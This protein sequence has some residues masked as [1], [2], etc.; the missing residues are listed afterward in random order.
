MHIKLLAGTATIAAS[1]LT[2]P[3]PAFAAIDLVY[4]G[5]YPALDQACNDQLNPN[6]N[7]DF[8]TYAIVSGAPSVSSSTV[9]TGPTVYVGIGPSSTTLTYRDA[10]VNGKSVNIHAYGDR[11]V[12][13]AGGAAGTTP[14][15]T[16]VVT[17]I[18]A[19]CHVHKPTNG[20]SPSDTLHNDF[21]APPGLQ[22]LTASSTSTDYITGTRSSSLQGPWID[23]NASSYGGEFV[24]C[25][26]PS[27][28]TVKGVP[29][30]WKGQNGYTNQLGR[31]CSTT[32]HDQLGTSVS[33]SLPPLP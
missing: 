12:T 11:V 29:G 1:L 14:T 13:Y 17:T 2:V 23:L 18:N 28:T 5:A 8:T 9:D 26:S 32:W 19:G 25:I 21:I 31:V 27:S 3:T 24:I 15:L 30:V 20:N 33:V 10:H 6:D 7:S 4:G 22:S 16:T